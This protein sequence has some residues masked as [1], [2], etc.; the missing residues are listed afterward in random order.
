MGYGVQPYTNYPPGYY[1]DASAAPS[2]YVQGW[3]SDYSYS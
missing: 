2:S 1:Q 3:S